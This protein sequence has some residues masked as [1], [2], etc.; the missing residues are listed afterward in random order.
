[1]VFAKLAH[2]LCTGGILASK[3]SVAEVI[4][5]H[6]PFLKPLASQLNPTKQKD[7]MF[8]LVFFVLSFC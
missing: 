8:Q 2:S 6:R 5:G 7:L 3:T 1:M 4:D